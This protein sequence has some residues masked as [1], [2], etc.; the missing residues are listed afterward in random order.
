MPAV[1]R[2]G[3]QREGFPVAA[4]LGYKRVKIKQSPE[5]FIQQF[6]FF[7]NSSEHH[8]WYG[9]F[10]RNWWKIQIY[11]KEQNQMNQF[12]SK[13][14]WSYVASHRNYLIFKRISTW[15]V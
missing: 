8:I 13:V 10:F 4:L 12:P 5:R 7:E 15:L 3:M 14:N 9:L 2:Q 6:G 1:F 11:G